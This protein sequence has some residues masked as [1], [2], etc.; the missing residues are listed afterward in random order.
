MTLQQAHDSKH[1]EEGNMKATIFDRLEV[2]SEI[3]K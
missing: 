3:R 2:N 1:S